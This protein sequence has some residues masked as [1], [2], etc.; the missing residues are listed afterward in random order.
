MFGISDKEQVIVQSS[1]TVI[2]LDREGNEI[3]RERNPKSP[4]FS[5]MPFGRTGMANAIER[6]G[7]SKEQNAGVLIAS[8]AEQTPAII[9][10]ALDQGA[11]TLK[12]MFTHHQAPEK[13]TLVR[14]FFSARSMTPTREIGEVTQFKALHLIYALDSGN[15]DAADLTTDLLRDC[16]RI[17]EG[18]SLRVSFIRA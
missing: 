13:E 11:L 6:V 7:A 8:V 1:V 18:Q 17:E 10:V 16:F 5:V 9:T 4:E 15:V 2:H 12:V 3:S 14:S